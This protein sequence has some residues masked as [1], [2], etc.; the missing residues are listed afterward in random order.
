MN[1]KIYISPSMRV[2]EI[3]VAQIICTSG[4]GDTSVPSGGGTSGGSFPNGGDVKHRFE[5]DF[6]FGG[7]D[8]DWSD[9]IW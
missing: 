5:D 7:S 8:S 3:K 1:K 2:D 6:D 4:L 9:G